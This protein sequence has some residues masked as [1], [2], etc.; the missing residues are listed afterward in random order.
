MMTI[1]QA[2]Q[3]ADILV[4]TALW[5]LLAIGGRDGHR[6]VVTVVE[7]FPACSASSSGTY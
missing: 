4:A 2:E 1:T 7:R 5:A 6:A 3:P